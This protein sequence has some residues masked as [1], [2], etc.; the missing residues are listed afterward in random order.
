MTNLYL[1]P[2]VA[3]DRSFLMELSGQDSS[4]RIVVICGKIQK[5]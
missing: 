2:L 3:K 4:T 5:N 1:K